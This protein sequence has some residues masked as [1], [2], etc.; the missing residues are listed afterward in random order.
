MVDAVGP[1][2]DDV[3]GAGVSKPVDGGPTGR[4]QLV[5]LVRG[6][7]RHL[8]DE[9]RRVR[10]DSGGDQWHRITVSS[11]ADPVCRMVTVGE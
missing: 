5:Q 7:A 10:A 3:P 8:G 9:Q 2:H 6:G 4:P 11:P 1:Q